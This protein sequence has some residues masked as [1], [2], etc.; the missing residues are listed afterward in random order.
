MTLDTF[1]MRRSDIINIVIGIF[2]V[3]TLVWG[4]A[5]VKFQVDANTEW[6]I[7]NIDIPMCVDSN[8]H[9]IEHNKRLPDQVLTSEIKVEFLQ[10]SINRLATQIEIANKN[11]SRLNRMFYDAD[12]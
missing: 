3:A 9:W 2:Y 6:R 5:F 4:V 1:K 10:D 12:K 8:T 11:F 7:A